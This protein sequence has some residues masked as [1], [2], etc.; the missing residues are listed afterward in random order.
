M[1]G[2]GNGFVIWSQQGLPSGIAAL[3]VGALPVSTLILDWLFFS[4]ARPRH[5]RRSAWRSGWRASW[6]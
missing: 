6:C 4:A 1:S 2:I 3:F 5:S